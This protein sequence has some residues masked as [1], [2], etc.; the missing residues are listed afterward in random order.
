MTL[1]PPLPQPFLYY[2]LQDLGEPAKNAYMSEC[3]LVS[4][5]TKLLPGTRSVHVCVFVSFGPESELVTP[6]Y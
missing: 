6:Q 5:V 2:S 4:H 1:C 3:F